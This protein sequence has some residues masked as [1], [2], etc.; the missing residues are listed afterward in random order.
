MFNIYVKL[1]LVFSEMLFF[2]FLYFDEIIF[3]FENMNSL[4]RYK[5][6]N[7]F[8]L[9]VDVY[10]FYYDLGVGLGVLIFFL[11]GLG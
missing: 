2:E 3:V 11:E 8:V 9:F 10:I 4:Y 1:D 6:L 7:N 5:F